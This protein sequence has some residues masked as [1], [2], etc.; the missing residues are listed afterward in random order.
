[1]AAATALTGA[2]SLAAIAEWAADA[3]NRSGS[4]PTRRGGRR[5]D[6]AGTT[7]AQSRRVHLPAAVDH[8]TQVVLAQRQVDGA[9]GEVPG[10]RPLLDGLDL[11]G[12]VV[13]ADAP[14]TH[15]DAAQ[16]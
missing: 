15:A 1:M 3:P 9:P 13:T 5:Q 14:H 4:R 10:F 16:S 6:G 12:V 2:R 7:D 8:T 11:A